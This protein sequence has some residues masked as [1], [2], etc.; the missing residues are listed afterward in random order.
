MRRP[1]PVLAAGALFLPFFLLPLVAVFVR[2][3]GELPSGTWLTYVVETATASRTVAILRFTVGQAALSAAVAVLVALPG[4]YL[5]SHVAFPGRRL[6]YSLSLLPF[7]LPSI[8]VVVAMIVFWG[9]NGVVNRALG[10]DLNIVYSFAGIVMAHVYYNLSLALRVLATAWHG[11]DGRYADAAGAL[12]DSRFGVF[13]RVTLPLLVPAIGSAF[14][15]VFMYS[16]LS[17]GVVLVFGGARWET[18]EVAIYREVFFNLDLPRAAALALVQITVS[19]IVIALTTRTMHAERGGIPGDEAHLRA[20]RSL[21]R[22]LRVAAIGY[23]VLIIGF[24]LGPL[25]AMVVRIDPGTFAALLLPG[26]GTRSVE[27]ILRSTVGAVILRSILLALVSGTLTFAVAAATALALRGR[28]RLIVESALQIPV[29][30]SLVTLGIGLR[31]VWIG[32]VPPLILVVL[33]Q[34][35]VAFPLVFRIVRSGVDELGER[36]VNAAESLGA[37]RRHIL[38]DIEW[39]LLRRT[40]I[41]GYAYAVALPFADLTMVMTVG[42]GRLATFPVAIYRLIGFRSF[43][44]ALAMAAIYVALCA[45]LFL[46]IDATSH[47]RESA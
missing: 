7:V 17:F 27:S 39:P 40:L 26:H 38:R 21:S 15:L 19:A 43:D 12:G 23:I 42:R 46:I 47:R 31:L 45:A 4:A 25:V 28:A 34:F 30:V 37:R 11:I 41:N 14:M 2:A 29:A 35:F 20:M 16:F 24:I 36:I 1:A 44:L 18:L 13:R 6:L 32:R 3:A 5:V 10:T 33:G 9:R 8:V 22:P